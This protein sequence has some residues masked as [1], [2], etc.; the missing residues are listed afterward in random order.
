VSRPAWSERELRAALASGQ[1]IPFFQPKIDLKTALPVG[2]EVL[3]RWQHP[4]FGLLGPA[5]FLHALE[6]TGLATDLF[7]DLFSQTLACASRW[8]ERG[9]DIG[10]AVNVSPTTLQDTRVPGR[11]AALVRDMDIAAPITIEITEAVLAHDRAALK[12]SADL[13]RQHGFMLAVDDF[14]TGLSG[15]QQLSSLPF[16]ELKIDRT[17]VAGTADRP[18][19]RVILEA[20]VDLANRL[21]L[22]T[23]AEGIETDCEL[24]LLEGIGCRLGQA[25]LLARPMAENKL[26]RYLGQTLRRPLAA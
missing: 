12:R 6:R 17:L 11:V 19:A 16:T 18:K 3:A 1:F 13:L 23:V 2:V 26:S 10:F 24:A 20:I 25:Y 5:D 15:L 14:G 21:H 4:V 8:G 7:F 9:W 22:D